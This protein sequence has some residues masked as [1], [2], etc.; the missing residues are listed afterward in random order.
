MEWA[1][2]LLVWFFVILSPVFFLLRQ[3][4]QSGSIRLPPEPPGWPVFGHLFNLGTTP[5]RTLARL[6]QQYGPIIWLRLGSTNTIAV[7]TAKAAAE[8]FKNH[9]LSFADR[10]ITDTNRSHDYY[11]GSLALA[12]YG[13]YWRFL[14][15]ICTVEMLVNKRI[16]ET[17]P[18]RQKC[19][20]D[21]LLWI[22]KDSQ[23]VKDEQ[24]IQV[25]WF[26]FLASFNM[27]GNL[28]VS[29][30]LADPESK[31]GS[32]FFTAMRVAIELAGQPN[33]SDLFPC[34]RWLDLQGLRRKIDRNLGKAMKI[35]SGFVK[36][37]MKELEENGERR[38]D[39]MDVLLEFEGTGKDEPAKLL[40]RDVT[41]FI[42]REASLC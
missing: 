8:L 16:S 29:R 10:T 26:V 22:E 18:I 7:L 30:D 25:A 3:R 12:P 28:V 34:L 24:G 37:R 33:I 17:V 36:E 23:L 2:S 32:E 38:K 6:K 11:L 27:I 13:S 5:H 40:E 9:D 1:W 19:V 42:L 15:R 4:P 14:R 20:N 35:A 31:V 21:M 41:I 39:F